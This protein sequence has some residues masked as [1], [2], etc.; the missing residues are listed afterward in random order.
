MGVRAFP[1]SDDHLR[2][3]V[4]PREVVVNVIEALRLNHL[5]TKTAPKYGIAA[6]TGPALLKFDFHC[7]RILDLVF[8]LQVGLE[9]LP[10]V[11]NLCACLV[12]CVNTQFVAL[13]YLQPEMLSAL[14]PFPVALTAEFFGTGQESAAVRLLV[15]LHVFPVKHALA[16]VLEREVLH[17]SARICAQNETGNSDTGGHRCSNLTP[18][19]GVFS[20]EYQNISSGI[21][22]GRL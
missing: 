13:P 10:P 11:A 20:L 6:A 17:T 18:R 19:Q 9:R 12:W 22:Q 7:L 15:P 2:G 21:S 14:V 3:I 4:P 5:L 1:R 16:S 8:L